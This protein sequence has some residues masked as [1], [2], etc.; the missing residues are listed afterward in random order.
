M[1]DRFNIRVMP[2]EAQL[3]RDLLD[4]EQWFITESGRIEME[5]VKLTSEYQRKLHDLNRDLAKI[6][7][8]KALKELGIR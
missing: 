2:S 6:R 3:E 5:R 4:L 7:E 1:T 8:V